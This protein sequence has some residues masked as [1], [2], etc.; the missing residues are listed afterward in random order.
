MQAVADGVAMARDLV[1]MPP[2]DLY[3]DSYAELIS[4]LSEF[5]LEVEIL[6]EKAMAD[7]QMNALLGVGQGS[8]RQSQTVVMK[9]MGANDASI[10]PH[11]S[12]W[13]RR[14]IRHWGH[15]PQA[16]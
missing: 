2:N 1:T 6:D 10:D 13:K 12:G 4:G 5:G 15:I 8:V 16:R 11:R 14:N 7:L 3:P 9:W